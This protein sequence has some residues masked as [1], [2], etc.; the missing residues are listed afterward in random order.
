MHPTIAV[1]MWSL[2]VFVV[3]YA[4]W[5]QFWAWNIS[6]VC[7][8]RG[9]TMTTGSR[10]DDLLLLFLRVAPALLTLYA[11]SQLAGVV[12]LWLDVAAFVLLMTF[13]G[14]TKVFLNRHARR[15]EACAACV[16][17]GYTR[18]V[19]EVLFNIF[20]VLLALFVTF[21]IVWKLLGKGG[22]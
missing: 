10:R 18:D 9:C 4:V 21:C 8:Y 22:I 2:Y 16:G 12:S 5:F 15:G 13:L 20:S 3:A 7:E 17:D 1:V 6:D 19:A 11:V 14:A